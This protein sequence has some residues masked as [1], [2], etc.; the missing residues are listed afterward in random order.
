MDLERKLNQTMTVYQK[1]GNFTADGA[2]IVIAPI[3]VKCR[4]ST[5]REQFVTNSGVEVYVKAWISCIEEFEQGD[6][7]VL[8]DTSSEPDPIVAGA[9]ELKRDSAIPNLSADDIMYIYFV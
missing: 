8:G 1:S 5:T 7:V 9:E 2:P 3:T 6:L 4:W